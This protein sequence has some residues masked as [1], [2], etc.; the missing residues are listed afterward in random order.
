[1]ASEGVDV[2]RNGEA[3]VSVGDGKRCRCRGTGERRGSCHAPSAHA[4]RPSPLAPRDIRT[5][6]PSPTTEHGRI[7]RE[8][9]WRVVC[10]F[11]RCQR[12]SRTAPGLKQPCTKQLGACKPRRQPRTVADDQGARRRPDQVVAVALRRKHVQI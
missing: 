2:S 7:L 12:D 9:A 3:E 1:M 4:P 10:A 5:P 11:G 8:S 6:T